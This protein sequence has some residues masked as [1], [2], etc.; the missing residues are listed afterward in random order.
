MINSDIVSYEEIMNKY[1]PTTNISTP[2][3]T[4]YELAKIIGL[5]MEQISRNAPSL[6]D[7]SK[8]DFEN[9]VTHEKFKLIVD[10]EIKKRVLPFMIVRNLP[11]GKKEFWK[12]SDMIIPGY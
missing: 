11:N 3:I 2:I 1:K 9:L 7:I 4:K 8:L 6:I 12:L 10:E 5:R